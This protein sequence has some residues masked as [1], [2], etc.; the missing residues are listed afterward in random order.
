MSVTERHRKVQAWL[1]EVFAGSSV[2][3]YEINTRTIDILTDLMKKN[4]ARDR[5]TEI[6]I[7]DL[8]QK[9]LE[10]HVEA[11]RLAS[12][13]QS[14]GLSSANLS[15]SGSLSLST[16]AN[17]SQMLELKDGSMSS[18]L[19]GLTELS[20]DLTETSEARL[21]EKYMADQLLAKTQN[22][23]IKSSYLKKHL[24]KLEEQAEHQE[25]DLK[26]KSQ[27]A[28]FLQTKARQYKDKLQH[29]QE[30]LNISGVDATIYH[31]N[32]EKKAEELKQLKKQLA[33]LRLKLDTYH[34]LPANP[35]LAQVQIEE[36]KREL[37]SLERE[38]SKRINQMNF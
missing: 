13:L 20:R 15:K 37:A 22:A 11:V 5:E 35:A 6:L 29:S 25:P 38:I 3:P 10:Y 21:Q 24:Q 16:L 17:I 31:H 18:Y 9:A 28:G 27:N 30:Q 26:K 8:N 2:P 32:L 1:D 7:E 23:R 36:A 19:L 14:I 4:E 34:Q 33:P 12:I